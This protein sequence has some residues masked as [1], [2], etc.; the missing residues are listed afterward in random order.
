[1]IET[2]TSQSSWRCLFGTFLTYSFN[3]PKTLLSYS[4]N[5]IFSYDYFL[6]LYNFFLIISSTNLK[7]EK[8]N[9]NSLLNKAIFGPFSQ[10]NPKRRAFSTYIQNFQSLWC[11]KFM[12]KNKENSVHQYELFQCSF[13]P[14][15]PS[16]RF[17]QRKYGR[18]FYALELL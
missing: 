13:L 11:Y 12:E 5:N 6:W 17:F 8:P 15:K 1:M 16:A 4:V 3:N 18:Q 14:K 10:K 2:I 7:Q 9:F